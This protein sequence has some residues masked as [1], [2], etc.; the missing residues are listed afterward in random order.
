MLPQNRRISKKDFSH[1]LSRGKR[2]NSEHFLLY[3]APTEGAPS[4]KSRVSFSVSKKV[5]KTAVGRNKQRRRGYSV[6]SKYLGRIKDGHFL[7]FSFKKG[8]DKLSVSAIEK[9]VSEL[10]SASGVI[11]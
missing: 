4:P 10:L 8:G 1:I 7:F 5:S 6:A 2:L 9:E 11:S 3:I